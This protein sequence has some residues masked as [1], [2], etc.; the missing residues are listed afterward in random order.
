M[1]S[2][3]SL[4]DYIR[5]RLNLRGTKFMCKE[6]GCGACIVTVSTADSTGPRTF[7]VN[8]V[9]PRPLSQVIGRLP[10]LAHS[11]VVA[12]PGVGDV[13]PRLASHHGGGAR[14]QTPRLPP[15]AAGASRAQRLTV[16]LLF[17][18]LGH[19]H[20]RVRVSAIFSLRWVLLIMYVPAL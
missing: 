9:R 2:D 15:A 16:R 4:N 13:V 8:S 5:G 14:R 12:V 7:A 20:A 11:I 10:Y 19:G 6:G 17:A 3:V 1:D 18:G